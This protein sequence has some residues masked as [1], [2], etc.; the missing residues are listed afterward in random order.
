MANSPVK[1][2]TCP[3]AAVV[4]DIPNAQCTESFGQVLKFGLANKTTQL[5][6][7]TGG[8]GPNPIDDQASWTAAL[9]ASDGTKV[10]LT[11]ILSD[12][13]L[14][15]NSPINVGGD[16]NTTPDG[17]PV[18]RAR[19]SAQGTAIMRDITAA[20]KV[21]LQ[22]YECYAGSDN[23]GGIY[24]MGRDFV[25]AVESAPLVYKP[26]PLTYFFVGD[27]GLGGITET[28]NTN[29][30]FRLPANWDANIKVVPITAFDPIE[31]QNP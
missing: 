27:K 2:C 9:G 15:A 19:T 10:Q 4:P 28:N 23:I 26:I 1:L 12:V 6:D 11:P 8:A 31:L 24:L 14:A 21:A 7:D 20:V 22:E 16:D 18:L 3:V 13:L 29:L 17:V 5:F 25:V 30:E